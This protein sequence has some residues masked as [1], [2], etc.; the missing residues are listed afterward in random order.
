MA[1][2]CVPSIPFPTGIDQ[3]LKRLFD[4]IKETLDIWAG[5]TR[6]DLCQV[7]T[8]EDLLDESIT[9][10]IATGISGTYVQKAGDV[11]TGDL[12][13][14]DPAGLNTPWV[15]LD[16]AFADG[17]IEG[18]LQWNSEDGTM[19]YGLPGGNVVLQVGQEHVV[20]AR[21]NTGSTIING[22][23]VYVTGAQGNRP[24]VELAQADSFISTGCVG[25][26]T[27]DILNNDNGYV[28]TIGLVR[29]IDTSHVAEGALVFLS[30]TVAGA[31]QSARPTA[32]NYKVF[33]GYA[34]TSH[35]TEGIVIVHPTI[36]P[37]LMSLSDV[38]EAVIGTPPS[39]TEFLRWNT[40]NARFELA[41]DSSIDHGTMA[42]LADDDHTQYLLIDGSRA[43]TG[44]LKV[45]S[46]I[47]V[48]ADTDILQLAADSLTVNG[49]V[50]AAADTDV[51]HTLGRAA[52]GH[53]LVSLGDY[54]GFAHLDSASLTGY[55][56]A[57]YT[58][59]NTYLNAPSGADITLC[60]NGVAYTVVDETGIQS[61]VDAD[62]SFVFGKSVIGTLPA[63]NDYAAFSHYDRQTAA[64]YGLLVY[65][66]GATFLNSAPGEIVH[67]RSNNVSIMD[68]ET[69]QVTVTGDMQVNGKIVAEKDTFGVYD[70]TTVALVAGDESGADCM[71]VIGNTL[72]SG[73]GSDAGGSWWINYRGYNG[74]VT[75]GRDLIIGDGKG[76][77]IAKFT[78][79][80]ATFQLY[81][82]GAISEFST[83]GTMAGDSDLAVPTE[84]AVVTY[85]AAE[86]AAIPPV[87]TV[88]Q[89]DAAGNIFG[90]T[91][92]GASITSADRN[93]FAGIGVAPILSSGV[94]TIL[95]GENTGR[96][97]TTQY[98][99][100]H[101][102]TNAGY[103][104]TSSG[105]ILV[106]QESAYYQTSGSNIVIGGFRCG[107]YNVT[108]YDNVKIG[109]QAG[110]GASGLSHND[111]TF[112][113]SLSGYGCTSGG[114]NTGVGS[115]TLYRVGTGQYNVG[116]GYQA[117]YGNSGHNYS[118]CVFIGYKAGFAVEDPVDMV[119]IGYRAGQGVVNGQYS[120][121]IGPDAGI[122][123]QNGLYNVG[124]GYGSL[125]GTI[126]Q[127]ASY[128]VGIGPQSGYGITSG[129]YNVL[130]GYQAGYNI[131][132]ALRSVF[133]G[134]QAGY[135]ETGSDK[136]YIANSNT[137][138]PLIKGD[139]S[140]SVLTV[141]GMLI[142]EK[143]TGG[144]YSPATVSAILGDSTVGQY[145]SI[146][147]IGNTINGCWGG[148]SDSNNLYLNYR[149]Y[150]GGAT[151]FRDLYIGDGKG[152][153]I[154]FIDGS[155]KTFGITAALG[156]TGAITTTSTLTLSAG[157]AVGEF[158]TDGTMAGNSDAAVPTEQAVVEYVTGREIYGE[159]FV[160][161][162]AVVT[163]V[164]S[165]GWT[166]I[167][168]LDTNGQSD[169]VTPDHTNDHLTIVTAGKYMCTVSA[170]AA[171]SAGVAHEIELSVFK[172]NGT[173]EFTNVHAQRTLGTGA[174]KGS[175]SLSGIIDLAASD[176][177]EL[178]AT[179]NS[180]A[181]RNITVSDATISLI[182][183]G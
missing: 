129:D 14:T 6:D 70:D 35:A 133:I 8:L 21:N 41:D 78:A 137:A 150:Y 10:Q 101:F 64:T 123:N 122:T 170:C 12:T 154:V 2:K 151:K 158:S 125:A 96:L 178:W 34:L 15:Q 120:C 90:G 163:S 119:C 17:S 107:Y 156:V 47:G 42:G 72:N 99:N 168:I 116:I 160:H 155:A 164:S 132:A 1:E 28:T 117:G 73:F 165:A 43:M 67:I 29:D 53:V 113:G 144:V 110:Y 24:T 30:P 108:G 85:V 79:T 19:E 13:I 118:N 166:Q 114:R 20:L 183:I 181:A 16:T 69:G 134:Y 175:I 105:S 106:G 140:T 80:T 74:G 115:R 98:G 9:I 97:L 83:D 112:I 4:P 87:V 68:L 141:N 25:L 71:Y 84:A 55:A 86:I 91:G 27:E 63:V 37:R 161:A 89:E 103:N 61:H 173:T 3:N 143:D 5:R 39:D 121:Y 7:I 146:Y 60:N 38:H 109:N 136:L 169:G 57:Q 93:F 145:D 104:N 65:A 176:T 54:A 81:A 66:G 31:F 75:R 174:D 162:N 36:V 49:V 180:G 59:G 82:G 52:I 48:S 138:T 102:G 171:N 135:N 111:C 177:I 95:I 88:F 152:T 126:G 149:G 179:S 153:A 172:N 157:A 26:A 127:V 50:A 33:I 124:I 18:R 46:D 76:T 100:I 44:G 130:I 62:K 167:T 51:V 22:S 40:A 77:Q 148:Q 23:C 11:M 182:K 32:P 56:V 92:T 45:L 131:A 142:V 94:D 159:I 139:F 147:T 128:N 58:D